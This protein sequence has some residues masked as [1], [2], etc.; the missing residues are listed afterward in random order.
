MRLQMK[1][2]TDKAY[3]ATVYCNGVKKEWWFKDSHAPEEW[4][5]K[6][7]EFVLSYT[8]AYLA[9]DCEKTQVRFRTIGDDFYQTNEFKVIG[10]KY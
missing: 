10:K 2:F 5:S 7:E 8:G 1:N 6:E 4:P 3:V 9:E